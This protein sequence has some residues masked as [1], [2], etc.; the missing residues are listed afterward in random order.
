MIRY[1]NVYIMV[2]RTNTTPPRWLPIASPTD[3]SYTLSN[4][5]TGHLYVF[6]VTAVNDVGES[7]MSVPLIARADAP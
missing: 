7:A 4:L 2:G 3:T 1:Y 6:T 5:I